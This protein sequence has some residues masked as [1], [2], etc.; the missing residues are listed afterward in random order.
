MKTNF[1]GG[2]AEGIMLELHV[3]GQKRI[4]YLLIVQQHLRLRDTKTRATRNRLGRD[5]CLLLF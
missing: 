5:K 3:F 4:F 1:L 2:G